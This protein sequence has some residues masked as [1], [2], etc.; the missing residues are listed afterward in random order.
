MVARR[1]KRVEKITIKTWKINEEKRFMNA[2][3]CMRC[4]SPFIHEWI[5]F[6][7][8]KVLLLLLF[9]SFLLHYFV[10]VFS[11]LSKM[12]IVIKIQPVTSLVECKTFLRHL[13][14]MLSSNPFIA[15]QISRERKRWNEREF[16]ICSTRKRFHSLESDIFQLN[17]RRQT[18]ICFLSFNGIKLVALIKLCMCVLQWVSSEALNSSNWSNR[19]W[20]KQRM[21][22]H[23]LTYRHI[24]QSVSQ[25]MYL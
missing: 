18:H 16:P 9:A 10:E 24:F 22:Q 4:N 7:Q 14:Y 20:W 25:R 23:I 1:E 5:K 15:I 13:S 19:R 6:F 11:L 3:H 21:L 17:C 12:W 8:K 2:V